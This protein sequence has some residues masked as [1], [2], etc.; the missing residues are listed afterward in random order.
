M[1]DTRLG[2]ILLESRI[3]REEDLERCLEIQALGGSQRPLG[4]ILVEQTRAE[5][6]PR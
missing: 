2:T 6:S 3:I 5:L 1:V 4:E